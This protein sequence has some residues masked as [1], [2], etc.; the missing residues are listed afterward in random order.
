MYGYGY[1]YNNGLVVGAG[2]G[3]PFANTKSLDFDGVDDYVS[4]NSKIIASDIT[5]SGWVNFNGSYSNFSAHFPMSITPSNTAVPNETIGRFYKRGTL[6]E[7][8]IQCYDQTGG[9]FSTYSVRSFDFEGA[10]WQHVCWTYN[11]TT[12][13]I[14]VYLNGI[15]QTWTNFGGTITTPY[16]T[17]IS[18]R[19]YESDL[20]VGRVKPATSTGTFL[21]L[22]DE[23]S[24][25][26]RIVTPAEIVTLS[27]A[28]TVDLTSLSPNLWLRNGDN[29]SYKSPQWLIPNNENKDK[30]SNY[31]LK[32]DGVDDD[33][34]SGDLSSLVDNKSKLSISFWVN[35]A[36]A[37]DINRITGK[38]SNPA[39]TS[40]WLSVNGNITNGLNFV[41]SNGGLAYVEA[42]NVLTNNTWHHI[43]CVF[44]GTQA[45]NVDR[46]KIYVDSVDETQSIIG[47]LP[48]TT[49]D[50]TLEPTNPT[51]YLGQVGLQLGNNELEGKLDEYAIY[52]DVALT[53]LEVN[54]IYN[55]G[56]PND[57][58]SLSVTPDLWYKMGEEATFSGGVWTVPDAVG[59]NDG[60]SNAM[61]IEDRVG[62]APSSENNAVTIN[63]DFVD[64]VPDTP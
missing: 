61:T 21:G 35:L 23:V 27:T 55:G 10:G 52:S 36:D 59:T 29:G 62:D 57:L 51:W 32:F 44:N 50:F 54:E 4:T 24:T 34:T 5:L 56:V 16:L 46:A 60:T 41:V 8:A 63:M 43:V 19:L 28:P 6:M 12:E 31:S 39:S 18:G 20:T 11:V 33:F 1:R 42:N 64:V 15:A 48:S 13:H 3:A 22:V 40:K 2:G 38:C 26:N 49:Y 9:N 58:S 45:V 14:Y 53:D 47:T 30:V 25:Y 17:A 7:I 37:T